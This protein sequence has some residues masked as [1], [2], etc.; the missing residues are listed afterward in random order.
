MESARAEA[1]HA[2]ASR[3][4]ELFLALMSEPRALILS[5]SKSC[6]HRER[7]LELSVRAHAPETAG[8]ERAIVWLWSSGILH[9]GA[10]MA[11]PHFTVRSAE[12]S[13]WAASKTAGPGRSA[14]AQRAD[15]GATGT[16][17]SAKAAT[18]ARAIGAG[19]RRP[20]VGALG[21]IASGGLISRGRRR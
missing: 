21:A 10:G 20:I 2:A 17:A 3:R 9:I 19:L 15:T 12:T 4:A 1:P 6:P 16:E 8:H 18:A 14:A 5:I 7:P 11:R 13:A